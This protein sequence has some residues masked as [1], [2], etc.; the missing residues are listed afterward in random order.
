VLVLEAGADTA[1]PEVRDNAAR[2]LTEVYEV[3]GYHAAATEDP[4]MCWSYSV[5]HYEDDNVQ[6]AD[7][8]YCR[9]KD[10]SANGKPGKGGILYPRSSGLGGCTS[11]YAMIVVKPNDRDWN[12]IATLTG[13]DSWRAENMQGYFA[14]IENCLYYQSY[15]GFLRKLLFIYKTLMRIAALLNP[16]SQLDPGGHGFQGW[17]K[18]SFI[19]PELIVRIAWKDWTFLRVLFGALGYLL[20]RKGQRAA[21]FRALL[22]LRPVQF[23]DPNFGN[24]RG[25]RAARPAFIAVGT[26]GVRRTG[27]RERLLAVS[28]EHPEHLVLRTGALVRRLIFGDGAPGEP[29]RAVGVEAELGPHAYEASPL[30]EAPTGEP[31]QF[32]ARREI[33]LAAGAFNTP[34]LLMLSG[35]GDANHLRELRMPGPRNAAGKAVC[36]LINLPGVGRNLQ[37]RY[38]VSVISTASQPFSTLQGVS[39]RPEDPDD[40]A[41]EQWLKQQSGL[42]TTNGG[43]LAFFF[44]SSKAPRDTPDI[45][46][47]GA[48]AAFRGYY[49]GWSKELLRETKGAPTERRDLWSWIL[50]KAYTRN[51]RGT[52]RLRDSSPSAQAEINF[53]SFD[54]AEAACDLDAIAE[55]I[56]FIRELNAHVRPFNHEIQPAEHGASRAQLQAWIRDEAWGH[57]ACG[58]CRIGSNPWQPRVANLTDNHAVIDSKFRVHGVRGL[59]IVDASIFPEIPGYFIVTPIF[60]IGEK[61]ADVLLADSTSYPQ[62]LEV[63]EAASIYRRRRVAQVRKLNVAAADRLDRL[64]QDAVGLALSGGGVRSAT[65]CLGVL[66]ALA[67]KRRLAEI[68]LLSTVSGGGYIAGFLGQLYARMKPQ[69]TDPAGR[70]RD[71]L[72][73][74]N[75]AEVWWLRANARYL[76]G[77]G[78]TDLETNTGT[79]WRNLL[80]IHVWIATLIIAAEAVLYWTAY[81]RDLIRTTDKVAGSLFGIRWS[82]WWWV[83]ASLV[84]FGLAPAWLSFWLSPKPGTRASLSLGGLLMWLVALASSIAALAAT[85][86]FVLPLVAIVALLSSWVWLEAAQW[87]IHTQRELEARGVIVRNRLTRGA[88]TVLGLF[89]L[90]LGWTLID[91]FADF[92]VH[93]TWSKWI[94][95]LMALIAAGLPSLRALVVRALSMATASSSAAAKATASATATATLQQTGHGFMQQSSQVSSPQLPSGARKTMQWWQNALLAGIGLILLA[96]LVFAL[97]VITHWA[98]D[99]SLGGWL[100]VSAL[101]ISIAVGRATDFVNLS[102]L[103]SLYAARLG[104]TYLGAANEARVHD[105]GDPELLDV[106][107]A[108]PDDDVF[109]QHY[110]PE[111]R[112]GPLHLINVCVNQTV[113]VTSGRQLKEDNGLPMCLG[114]EGVS[115]GL[116]Y[117]ALWDACLI[118]EAS[119]STRMMHLLEGKGSPLATGK[120]ALRALPVAADPDS[121]HVLASRTENPVPVEP[122]RLSQWISISGAAFTTGEGRLTSRPLSFLL[123][124]FNVRLGYWWNS[125]IDEGDRPGQYPPSLWRHLKSLPGHVFRTQRAILNEWRAYFA[126]PSHRLWYLSDGGHYDNTGLYELIR[127]RLPFIIAVDAGHDP[128]Y[129]FEDL[130]ILQR[131]VRLDFDAVVSWIDPPLESSS[132]PDS[133][134]VLAKAAGCEI[135]PLVRNWLEPTALGPLGTIE[136]RGP[137]AAAL[138]RIDYGDRAEASWL[139]VL[140]A[141]LPSRTPLPLDVCCYAEQNGSFPNQSSI[142]QFFTDDQWESYRL[143]GQ[144]LASALFNASEQPPVDEKSHTHGA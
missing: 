30:Y 133:W 51:K 115:V 73:A 132:E 83:P 98:F 65:F 4:A 117:H 62:R 124:L 81:Q 44:Q 17:Q 107:A 16:R 40:P 9:S 18:T 63:A 111:R 20:G 99:H 28:D 95:G 80:A 26:D 125:H 39:F 93:Q 21:L 31:V 90:A 50:L 82:P 29:P 131:I 67:R 7:S 70:V 38:E 126:G 15:E 123:G 55:G 6:R 75:S 105:E 103:Q 58:T 116:R 66:Q 42:Y 3:P 60:M 138:A 68:D 127:R 87:G 89:L 19:D 101:L 74:T 5:R 96:F 137:F 109:L 1:R 57:H 86:A 10:P 54:G 119:L 122:L 102:S 104:R 36:D 64:P 114:P 56:E 77:A 45:F 143:L 48:P 140:K 53:Q 130:A 35:I 13:D 144:T 79:I 128:L 41:R 76:T 69:V 34:Q 112:G 108:H 52:V 59:R 24:D 11:H 118:R 22:S 33:I 37:D 92:A 2:P 100:L 97:D 121:F 71:I 110:H 8:K 32:F 43:A 23:L 139:V 135:P 94:P 25:A 142:D 106:D 78:L 46:I 47:F 120:N 91:T 84:I 88:G 136:R 72:S 49:W 113:D 27:L 129:T 141:C 134:S 12:R 61:A 14:R 85:E